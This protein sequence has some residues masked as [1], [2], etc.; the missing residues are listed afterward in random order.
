MIIKKHILK[1]KVLR[2]HMDK[3]II[4]VTERFVQHPIYQKIVKKKKKIHVHD[5][6]NQCSNGDI[7]EI[8][9]CRP[10]SRKKSWILIK[11]IKKFVV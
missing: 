5:S 1:G 4:V 10:I 8:S 7:V 9:S 11:V 2:S 3:S 6:K